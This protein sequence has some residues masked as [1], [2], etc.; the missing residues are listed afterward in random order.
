[1]GPAVGSRLVTQMYFEGDPM[2]GLDPIFNAVPSHSRGRM[3][4]AYD[5]DVTE[6]N[7]ATGYRWDIVIR[8]RMATPTD[9]EVG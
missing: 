8:G 6:E 5:H 2:L 1:M 4:A 3:I 9:P 7:W